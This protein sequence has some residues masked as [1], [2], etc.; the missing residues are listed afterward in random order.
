[1]TPGIPDL[2]LPV[3]LRGFNGWFGEMKAKNGK[4]TDAQRRVLHDLRE[5][6]YF[7]EVFY[8]WEA[9]RES[10]LWYVSTSVEKRRKR[11]DTP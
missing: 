3:A 11:K 6:G 9:A 4:L 1:V 2:F 7:A 8:G 10:L 5:H